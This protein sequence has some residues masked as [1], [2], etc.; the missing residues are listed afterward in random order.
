MRL[1]ELHLTVHSPSTQIERSNKDVVSEEEENVA[2]STDDNT[3]ASLRANLFSRSLNFGSSPITTVLSGQEFAEREARRRRLEDIMA[4]LKPNNQSESA[5]TERKVSPS[6]SRQSLNETVRNSATEILAMPP[7]SAKPSDPASSME[8]QDHSRSISR[9]QSS[10][11]GYMTDPLFSNDSVV[12]PTVNDTLESDLGTNAPC[13]IKPEIEKTA[14]ITPI[15]SPSN[16]PHP[17]RANVVAN[18]L[19]SGRLNVRSRAATILLNLASGRPPTDGLGPQNYSNGSG[20]LERLGSSKLLL[21]SFAS[22]R[23]Q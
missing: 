10:T 23:V 1:F 17:K 7:I 22:H 2:H 20:S 11:S 13:L 18:L 9:P 4:R 8:L 16:S 5:Q 21:R 3:A 15:L 19:A 6:P 12:W 14:T